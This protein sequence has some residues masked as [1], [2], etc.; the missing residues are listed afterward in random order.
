MGASPFLEILVGRDLEKEFDKAVADAQYNYGHAGYTGSIAE[1]GGYVNVGTLPSRLSITRLEELIY[2]Y[3]DWSSAND[4]YNR[5][6]GKWPGPHPVPETWRTFVEKV[7]PLYNDK[8]GPAVVFEVKGG[9]A[10]EIKRQHRREGSW[11]RVW[12]AMGLA[13]E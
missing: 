4:E 11:D 7:T 2:E 3:E 6:G 1:K 10:A 13:S 9:A 12:V 5:N 8:W